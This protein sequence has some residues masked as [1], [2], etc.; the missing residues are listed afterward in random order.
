MAEP[1]ERA[2]SSLLSDDGRVL[3][4]T[5]P[6]FDRMWAR[7]PWR[8]IRGC[9][10]RFVID[11]KALKRLG[12]ERETQP[13]AMALPELLAEL[14]AEQQVLATV[15]GAASAATRDS[16]DIAWFA[17]SHTITQSSEQDNSEQPRL[18][19]MLTYQRDDGTFIHTLNTASGLRRKL[20]ALALPLTPPHS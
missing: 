15:L 17:P 18:D 16:I 20:A 14:A 12:G 11:A 6:A 3:E 7:F 19:G 1:H 4:E 8:E 9:P 5:S 10:G 2:R 13:S